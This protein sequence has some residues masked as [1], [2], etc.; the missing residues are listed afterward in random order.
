[1]EVVMTLTLDSTLAHIQAQISG[2][3]C[4]ACLR[5]D[6]A[7]FCLLKQRLVSPEKDSYW[8]LDRVQA[9]TAKTPT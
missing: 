2:Q 7:N 9:A 8:K 4:G 3:R 1:M 6:E 5:L